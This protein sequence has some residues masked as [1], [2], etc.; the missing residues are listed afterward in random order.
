M[1]YCVSTYDP[2]DDRG[3]HGDWTDVAVGVSLWGLRSILRE[4]YGQGYSRVS[5]RVDQMEAPKS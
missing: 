1:S 5:I 3:R 4:L 2:S